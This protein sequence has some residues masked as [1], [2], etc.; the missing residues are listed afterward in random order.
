[1]KKFFISILYLIFLVFSPTTNADYG[2]GLVINQTTTSKLEKIYQQYGYEH[3]IAVQ[4]YH[5]PQ[6]Y[7][8]HFPTDFS[9]I[10][11]FKKRNEL[12]IKILTPL[13]LKINQEIMQ[14]RAKMIK[15]QKTFIQKGGLSVSETNYLEQLAKKYDVFTRLKGKERIELQF[16]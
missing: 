3:Y 8:E 2:N 7:L 12:F 11:D 13:A 10:S 15:L 6:I 4:D 5:I 14:E 9:T 1:M 16:S